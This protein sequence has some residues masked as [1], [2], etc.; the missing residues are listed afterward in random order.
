VSALYAA[1]IRPHPWRALLLLPIQRL[2]ARLVPQAAPGRRRSLGLANA[3]SF[4]A[5]TKHEHRVLPL[6][7]A[8]ASFFSILSIIKVDVLGADD[9]VLAEVV[10][11][12]LL[13]ARPRLLLLV[14]VLFR[15]LE[16]FEKR[17]LLPL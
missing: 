15:V 13:V 1:S 7:E 3:A 8:E 10:R 16:V 17:L 9:H 14:F 2:V 5:S 12:V 6:I 4:R 11:C